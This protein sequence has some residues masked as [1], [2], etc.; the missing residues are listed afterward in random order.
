MVTGWGSFQDHEV[1]KA[2]VVGT[3]GTLESGVPMTGDPRLLS[4]KPF[5]CGLA[6]V[7]WEVGGRALFPS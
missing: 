2:V 3:G 5:L 6:E 4:W 1:R 7:A